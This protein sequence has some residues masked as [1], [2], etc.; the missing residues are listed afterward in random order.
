MMLFAVHLSDGV[1]A[2]PWLFVGFIPAAILV[3]LAL[4][5]I[6]DDAI[7]RVALLTAAFFVSSLIHV[8]LGP[9]S[10]HLL[11]TGLLGVVLGRR[12]PLAIIV[13]LT[14]QAVLLGHGGF[15]TLGWNST[16][17]AVPA[18]LARGLF[19]AL[20]RVLPVFWCGVLVGA[21]AV[22][23]TCAANAAVLLFAGEED[24]T[25]LAGTMFAAHAPLAAIEGLILGTTAAY[26][27]KV[28]P[29]LLNAEREMP[30]GA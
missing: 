3:A 28:K 29:E 14:L 5:Q 26:L 18:L 19:V 30:R 22:L 8:R 21:G 24:Y 11:L 20:R 7:P 23:A 1:L 4:Y 16:I 9:T 13:G 27:A 25:I 2:S 17:M 12:A 15:S 10:V 6:A